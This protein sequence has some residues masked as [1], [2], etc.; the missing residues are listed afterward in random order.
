MHSQKQDYLFYQS[1]LKKKNNKNRG[2]DRQNGRQVFTKNPVG[3]FYKIP[4]FFR[5]YL[6]NLKKPASSKS[7]FF[8]NPEGK[9]RAIIIATKPFKSVLGKK[10]YN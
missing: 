2:L 6:K 8:P 10:L 7:S 4:G 5:F 3:F 1:D 9:H